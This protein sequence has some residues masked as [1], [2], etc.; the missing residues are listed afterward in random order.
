MN[1]EDDNNFNEFLRIVKNGLSTE[2]STIEES[3]D[4]INVNIKKLD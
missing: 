2:N 3:E 4:S 1:F